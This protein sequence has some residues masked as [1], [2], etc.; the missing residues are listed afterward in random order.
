[1]ASAD[2]FGGVLPPT[3]TAD[4]RM[5]LCWSFALA[6][7]TCL[8]EGDGHQTLNPLYQASI[9]RSGRIL[10]PRSGLRGKLRISWPTQTKVSSSY[11][12]RSWRLTSVQLK[13]RLWSRY[14]TC[15]RW[16]CSWPE[17]NVLQEMRPDCE[18]R[19]DWH[20]R[21]KIEK[22]MEAKMTKSA[23][24]IRGGTSNHCAVCGGKFGLIRHYSWRTAFCS[25]RCKHHFKDRRDGDHKLRRMLRGP[26][27]TSSDTVFASG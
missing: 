23:Q 21:D 12:F 13:N 5:M 11:S 22:P 25:R 24:Q 17:T 9:L 8:S 20:H 14:A 3:D 2:L 4:L 19:P 7:T 26:V 1:M 15:R 6:C 16:R 18:S 27:S 10:N